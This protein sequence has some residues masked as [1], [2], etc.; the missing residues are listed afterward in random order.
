MIMKLFPR[1]FFALTLFLGAVDASAFLISQSE[2]DRQ[3]PSLDSAISMPDFMAEIGT[4]QMY[5]PIARE[6][7][8]SG[9]WLMVDIQA[10]KSIKAKPTR[11]PE[12]QLFILLAVGL[13]GLI[14]SRRKLKL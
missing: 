6:W 13:S 9:E 3:I 7:R 11:V 12:P 1:F 4:P 5:L 8:L 2:T 10:H 14:L